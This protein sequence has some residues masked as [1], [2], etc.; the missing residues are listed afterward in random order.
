LH[1]FFVG[2]EGDE[3]SYFHDLE[4]VYQQVLKN[5]WSYHEI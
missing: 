1:L 3:N 4:S 5:L 2:I